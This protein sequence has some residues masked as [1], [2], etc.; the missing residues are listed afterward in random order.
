MKPK[1]IL[2]TVELCILAALAILTALFGFRKGVW[3][4]ATFFTRSSDA[5]TT[6]YMGQAPSKVEVVLNAI[7]SC[8]NFSSETGGKAQLL[9]ETS[10]A[11]SL[12]TV[13][14]FSED[15]VTII[16]DT[17]SIGEGK[18]GSTN[19]GD[20]RIGDYVREQGNFNLGIS[21]RAILDM[22]GRN[23][24]IKVSRLLTGFLLGLLFAALGFAYNF[25]TG[26][27]I[28]LD[29]F[30]LGVFYDNSK[31]LRISEVGKDLLLLP[32]IIL[33]AVGVIAW[34][35]ILLA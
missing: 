24:Q 33:F 17:Y 15:G 31:E 2:V 28:K 14:L 32:G 25:L 7:G 5:N 30:L 20:R 19:Y 35:C 22:V 12:K 8:V 4:G 26:A 34:A 9:F 1:R 21:D 3:D 16:S 6:T 29:K 13:R 27:I 11:N 23:D 10:Y 18:W